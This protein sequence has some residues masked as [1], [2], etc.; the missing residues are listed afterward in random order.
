ML[1]S[2]YLSKVFSHYKTRVPVNQPCSHQQWCSAEW[3]RVRTPAHSRLTVVTQ[4]HDCRWSG[5]AM[6]CYRC[7]C[8]WSSGSQSR[9]AS[10]RM[11]FALLLLSRKWS[12]TTTEIIFQVREQVVS[13]YRLYYKISI[14]ESMFFLSTVTKKY[15]V[16]L[17]SIQKEE[18]SSMLDAIWI[19][20]QIFSSQVTWNKIPCFFKI[21][22]QVTGIFSYVKSL[23]V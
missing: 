9:V 7:M 5:P 21:G 3:C 23:L 18:N 19:H 17:R 11:S 4:A 14:W 8:M 10:A 13:Y 16:K 6:L 12:N 22:P 15:W 1:F 2:K 20:L